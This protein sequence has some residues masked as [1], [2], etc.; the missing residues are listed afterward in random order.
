MEPLSRFSDVRRERLRRKLW[1][2]TLCPRSFSIVGAEWLTSAR[3]H[4][5]IAKEWAG[6]VL[7]PNSLAA[8]PALYRS[9]YGACERG[10]KHT[11]ARLIDSRSK[12]WLDFVVSDHVSDGYH[13]DLYMG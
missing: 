13:V 8:Q 12:A 3:A 11:V 6:T 4:V 1:T 10:S 9:M 2:E 5:Y 7:L